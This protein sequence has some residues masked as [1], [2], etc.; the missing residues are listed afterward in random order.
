[1]EKFAKHMK[2][3]TQVVSRI[4]H[5]YIDVDKEI[6]PKLFVNKLE[7]IEIIKEEKKKLFEEFKKGEGESIASKY[8]NDKETHSIRGMLQKYTKLD[9]KITSDK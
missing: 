1:M 8:A 7:G 5:E 4:N 3:N 2:H 6:Y 9:E